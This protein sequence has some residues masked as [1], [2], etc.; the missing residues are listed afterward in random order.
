MLEK[1]KFEKFTAFEKLEISLSIGINI[2]IGA[3]GTGKTH[4][5][6]ALYA[7]SE[8]TKSKK[9]LAEK[10]NRVF[11]PS[12]EQMSRLVTKNNVSGYFEV[13]RR[14]AEIQ[15]SLTIRLTLN[16][17]KTTGAHKEWLEHSLDSVYIPVKDMM[18]NAPGFRSLY[19]L[20]NIHFE[21]VYADIIDRVFLGALRAP[22]HTRQKKLLEILQQAMNGKIIT[23]NEEFFLK[24][25]H[26]ELEFTLLAEG[27][28][29]LGLLWVLIQNGT[30]LNGSILCWD[31]PEANLNPKLMYIVV[32]ILL[33]L[34]R[35]GVQIFI[36]THDYVILKEFDL[37]LKNTD[38]V[39]FHSLYRNKGEIEI[40][41]TENYLNI[42]PNVIDDTFGSI[43]DREINKSMGQLGK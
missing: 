2:F 30:L 16:T 40:A 31:E 3:N 32:E 42:S 8:I 29:K 10:I 37:Q 14:V 17:E 7:T 34:Q 24:N 39:L 35:M 5:L 12:G 21:E 22:I 20:R 41:S 9:S 6:K 38:K 19:N 26:G 27:I 43:V 28:R 36:S 4:I 1:I 15:N 25:K 13:T 11:L 33:E 18:A 23:K